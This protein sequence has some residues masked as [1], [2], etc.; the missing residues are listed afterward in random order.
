MGGKPNDSQARAGHACFGGG[1]PPHTPVMASSRMRELRKT[2]AV[3]QHGIIVTIPRLSSVAGSN[4]PAGWKRWSP[5]KKPSIFS[6][7]A[8]TV[9]AITFLGLPMVSI[10]VGLRRRKSSV[11]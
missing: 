10:S 2:G 4:K 7:S 1:R 8:S 5:A 3:D 11:W 6:A 9:C